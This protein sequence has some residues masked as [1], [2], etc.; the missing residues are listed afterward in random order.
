MWKWGFRGKSKYSRNQQETQYY[1]NASDRDKN[2]IT[3]II[4]IRAV[5]DRV[6]NAQQARHNQADRHERAKAKRD[7]ITI[8]ALAG[9]AAV[10]AWGILRSHSDTERALRDARRV[11]NQQHDDTLNALSRAD[12]A[13]TTAREAFTTVQRPFIVFSG[14]HTIPVK[15]TENFA[16]EIQTIEENTGNTIARRV[17]SHVSYCFFPQG[18]PDNFDFPDLGERNDV[19]I[20]LGPKANTTL[21][22]FAEPVAY[23]KVIQ[24]RK[25]KLFIWGRAV[26]HDIFKNT[27]THITRFCDEL[28]VIA[29]DLV[30]P[31]NGYSF[32]FTQCGINN[33]VDNDC[34][35]DPDQPPRIVDNPADIGCINLLWKQKNRMLTTLPAQITILAGTA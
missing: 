25:T 3:G 19:Y 26:Y 8:L 29:G 7:W 27:E 5:I 6:A 18:I 12:D 10:A 20:V 22:A 32:T 24:D 35:G 1:Q 23:L 30:E 14:F 33:C 15:P 13:N 17:R 2:I 31:R 16:W 34:S 11:A 4:D 21:G 28:S 9:A